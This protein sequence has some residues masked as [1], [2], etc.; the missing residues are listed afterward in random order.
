MKYLGLNASSGQ[1]ISDIHHVRQSIRDILVTPIGSR[2]MRRSY[3]SLLFRLIDQPDNK[4]LRLQLMAACYSALLQWEPRIEIQ[5]LTI[6]TPT[7][8]NI[9]IELSGVFNGTQQPFS[10]SVP[11][12]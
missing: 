8:S 1:G 12:R 3:G 10:F 4:T 5:Q 9:V 7:A 11:V 6:C 2:L